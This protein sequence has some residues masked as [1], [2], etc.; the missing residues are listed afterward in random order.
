M[1]YLTILSTQFLI[2]FPSPIALPHTSLHSHQS[3]TDSPISSPITPTQSS[4]SLQPT[5]TTLPLSSLVY[6]ETNCAY[7]LIHHVTNT[8]QPF[9][10]VDMDK[11]LAIEIEVVVWKEIDR[12]KMFVRALGEWFNHIHHIKISENDLAQLAGRFGLGLGSEGSEKDELH[13]QNQEDKSRKLRQINDYGNPDNHNEYSS[14][15]GNE[16]ML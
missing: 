9:S 11:N 16:V 10:Y 4:I 8:T 12:V 5:P 2:L 3:A 15:T 1:D 14:S 13:H 7:Y 6:N